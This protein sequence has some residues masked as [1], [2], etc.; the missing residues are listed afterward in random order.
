MYSRCDYLLFVYFLI[1]PSLLHSSILF[2]CFYTCM[3]YTCGVHIVAIFSAFWTW[4]C[5]RR[6]GLHWCDVCD[7]TDLSALE[8]VCLQLPHHN[9]IFFIFIIV[10][11]FADQSSTYL[12]LMI[13]CLLCLSWPKA[14]PFHRSWLLCHLLS[15]RITLA[16]FLLPQSA[17]PMMPVHW[18]FY[19]T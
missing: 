12:K 8:K 14:T 19:W 17:V 3:I 2:N 7:P 16:I 5:S 18:M 10:Y 15:W 6:S 1:L 9:A 13:W 11:P 4:A